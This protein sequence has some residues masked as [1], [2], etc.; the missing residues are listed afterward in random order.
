[1]SN[2][3]KIPLASNPAR[4]FRSTSITIAGSRLA[5][6]GT[7]VAGTIS[8]AAATSVVPAGGSAATFAMTASG[9]AIADVTLTCAAIGEGYNY[10]NCVKISLSLLTDSTP[11]GFV[12]PY[13]TGFGFDV[14]YQSKNMIYVYYGNVGILCYKC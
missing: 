7:I 10:H 1:M 12:P 8:A 9:T 3:I 14:T 5:G 11:L 6:G 4:S 13:K 2:Y